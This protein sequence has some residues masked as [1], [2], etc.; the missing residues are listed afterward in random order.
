VK[1]DKPATPPKAEKKGKKSAMAALT[2][3]TATTTLVAL[4]AATV[5]LVAAGVILSKKRQAAM[6]RARVQPFNAKTD[7]NAIP[8]ADDAPPPMY[9]GYTGG[10]DRWAKVLDV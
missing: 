9:N 10:D 6:A 8:T 5:V 4:S 7:A 1:A 2:S 3:S